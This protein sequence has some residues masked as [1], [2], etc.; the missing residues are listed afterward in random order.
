MKTV[1][2]RSYKIEY[3]LP[4][5]KIE[6]FYNIQKALKWKEYTILDNNQL[7]VIFR[8]N[9]VPKLVYIFRYG[10]ISFMNF[11]EEEVYTFLRHL[12]SIIGNVDYKLLSK[13]NESHILQIDVNGMCRLWKSSMEKL[14]YKGFYKH[15]I[16][17]V[18]A[19]STELY[20]LEIEVERLLDQA[21]KFLIYLQR[22]SLNV[23]KKVY[24]ASITKVLRLEYHIINNIKIFE[25]DTFNSESFDSRRVYD[26]LSEYYELDSRC[27]IIQNKIDDLRGIYKA[28]SSFSYRQIEARLI[29]LEIFMLAL[30][31]LFYLIRNTIAVKSIA[32]FVRGFF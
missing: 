31:P 12:E 2:F 14:D 19:K 28:Y 26:K 3:K 27:K 10:C 32:S 9:S 24:I 7:K 6:T 29:W 18:L 23:N 4:L 8:F 21:E 5:E 30:F 13:Y 25:R 11:E 16:N 22:G 1:L 15:I 17:I 20:V